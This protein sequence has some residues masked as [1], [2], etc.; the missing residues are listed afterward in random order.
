L[1]STLE[2]TY[3]DTWHAVDDI[4]QGKVILLHCDYIGEAEDFKHLEREVDHRNGEPVPR[5]E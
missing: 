3:F 5:N 4:E 2:I 1:I